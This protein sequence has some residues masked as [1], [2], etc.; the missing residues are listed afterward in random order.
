MLILFD[1]GYECQPGSV[2][3]FIQLASHVGLG[4]QYKNNGLAKGNKGR[5]H[6]IRRKEEI[7]RFFKKEG[8]CKHICLKANSADFSGS[9]RKC[10]FRMDLWLKDKSSILPK[11]WESRL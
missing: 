8:N 11:S 4:P 9:S 10:L 3:I 6:N 5:I 7:L 1:C 2:E